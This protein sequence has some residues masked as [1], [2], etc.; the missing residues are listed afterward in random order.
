[1]IMKKTIIHVDDEI[2]VIIRDNHCL[3]DRVNAL[4][5]A[6]YGDIVLS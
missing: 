4:E 3:A 2:S 5:A 1:M 6:G